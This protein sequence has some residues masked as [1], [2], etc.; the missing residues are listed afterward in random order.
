M[1]DDRTLVERLEYG[2]CMEE[3]CEIGTWYPLINDAEATMKEAAATIARQAD[4]I[5]ALR[6]VLMQYGRHSSNCD[7]TWRM[8]RAR[9]T[10]GWDKARDVLDRSKSDD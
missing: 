10:C 2:V 1:T 4:E 7:L 6:R 9:C 5:A 3:D 8:P